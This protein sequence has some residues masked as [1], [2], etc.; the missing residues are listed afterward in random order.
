MA[1]VEDERYE[2]E[3]MNDSAPEVAEP[4]AD[5]HHSESEQPN[6]GDNNESE[7]QQQSETVDDTAEDSDRKFET[8]SPPID[9]HPPGEALESIQENT[10]SEE[11]ADKNSTPKYGEDEKFTQS[12]ITGISN[13]DR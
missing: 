12:G 3:E 1:D 2:D 8:D 10:V 6:V 13:L 7:V 11:S 5:N 4:G 9:L